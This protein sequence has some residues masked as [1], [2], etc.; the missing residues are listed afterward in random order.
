MNLRPVKVLERETIGGHALLRY[1]WSGRK[2]EPGQFVGVKAGTASDPFLPRPFFVHDAEEGEISLLF[3]VRGR[4][5]E[6]I[7]YGG[8]QLLVSDPR[9]RGFELESASESGRAA[10]VGG[11]VWVAP[12]RFLGRRLGEHGVDHSVYLEAPPEASEEYLSWLRLAHPGA[13]VVSTDGSPGAFGAS[14]EG[15]A[16]CGEV[17]VSGD[18]DTLRRVGRDR[19]DAQLALRE[20]MACMDGSCY[21]CVVPAVVGGGVSYKRVCVDGPVFIAWDLAW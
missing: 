10:L 21:G 6:S 16:G 9:G 8:E 7:L 11:G 2:P 17:Y 13:E 14:L 19:P 3:K 5:T 15:L 4:G 18:R 1:E 20:R 12:L